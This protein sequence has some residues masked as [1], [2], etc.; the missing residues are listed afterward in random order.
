[1]QLRG[2]ELSAEDVALHSWNG[3]KVTVKQDLLLLQKLSKEACN[4]DIGIRDEGQRYHV[5]YMCTAA[6]F[7]YRS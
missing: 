3:S 6:S 5:L 1:M 2:L 4:I 7:R